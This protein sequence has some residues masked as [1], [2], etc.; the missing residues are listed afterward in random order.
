MLVIARLACASKRRKV[1]GWHAARQPATGITR[2]FAAPHARENYVKVWPVAPPQRPWISWTS[3]APRPSTA[4]SC[5]LRIEVLMRRSL[6]NARRHKA[7]PEVEQSASRLSRQAVDGHE[8]SLL[9]TLHSGRS[10]RG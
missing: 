1:D 2:C 3:E 9:W 7:D 5:G 6:H 4:H 10:S 8:P